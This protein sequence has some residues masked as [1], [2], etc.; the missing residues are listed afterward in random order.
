MVVRFARRITLF[1]DQDVTALP[2]LVPAVYVGMK[3][4]EISRYGQHDARSGL[5]RFSTEGFKT[6]FPN[7][8]KNLVGI[9]L[10]IERTQR[11]E[12]WL[13]REGSN[14]RMAESKSAALPLGYAP[15][16]SFR[17]GG[18][19]PAESVPATPVYRERCGISTRLRL[20]LRRGA[21]RPGRLA[22][23]MWEA[24]RPGPHGS[25]RRFA[26]PHHEG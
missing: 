4:M 8:P 3:A 26:P 12:S 11:F 21:A 10:F 24:A 20:R 16:G 22:F 19:P 2:R 23:Y 15:T 1:Y 7:A 5:V 14:L 18:R 13:G 25:R 6:S 9:E 17:N